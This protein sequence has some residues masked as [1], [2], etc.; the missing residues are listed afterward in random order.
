MPGARGNGREPLF[1]REGVLDE[2]DQLLDR[3]REGTGHLL[4]LEGASGSGKTHVIRAVVDRAAGRDV[5]VLFGRALPEELPVPFSLVRDLVGSMRDAGGG[6]QSSDAVEM[7]PPFLP[8]VGGHLAGPTTASRDDVRP[9]SA[10]DD[11]DRI[12]APLGRSS[13][14]GLEAGR[15]GLLGKVAEYFRSLTADRPIL[16]AVDDL[17]FADTS[18]L[19]F[20][21]RFARELPTLRAVVVATVDTEHPGSGAADTAVAALRRA[22]NFRSLDVRPL[23]MPEATEFVRWVLG[24]REPDRRDVLRWHAQTEGNPLF[25][26][27]LVRA[28][29]G[30]GPA[31]AARSSPGSSATEILVARARGL[32]EPD[33]RVLTYAAVLGK[34]FAFPDLAAVVGLPEDRV[35]E[36]LDRLVQNGLVR[37]KGNEVYEF[38]TEAV[39]ARLYSDLTETRRRIL[40]R[41]AGEALEARGGP[42]ASELARQFYLGRD[43]AR[44][45]RYCVAAADV[46]L[47]SYAFETAAAHLARA[48]E[49][50][51]R[52]PDRDRRVE[53][54]LLT[55]LGRVHNEMGHREPSEEAFAE[56]IRLARTDPALALELGRG[57]LGLADARA[58]W[59]EYATAEELATEASNLLATAGTDRDRMATHRVLSLVHWRQG[60]LA[61]AEENARA[62]LEIAEREGTPLELGHALVDLAIVMSPRGP[63]R[64]HPALELLSRAAELFARSDDYSARARAL[65]DRAVL[66]HEAARTDEALRDIAL[67]I[68]AAER[69]RS[70][71]WI[72]YCHLNLAQWQAARGHPELARPALARAV[73]VLA[74]SGD[75]LGEQQAE[76]ARGMIAHADHQFD[77]AEASYQ[78]ALRQSHAM[79]LGSDALESLVRLAQL[80]H[81]R[82]DDDEARARVAEVRQNPY[83]DHRRDLAA[84]VAELEQAL[85]V[86]SSPP[87]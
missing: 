56:A 33:R 11:L 22:P 13:V 57:L 25:L 34:E 35:T 69:S 48:L 16:I 66:E 20:L 68:D 77:R 67:A 73:Q 78:E 29:I 58:G 31:L 84:M 12:L 65:M 75:R 5:R 4:F 18:S 55:D 30:E 60:D 49:A 87:R 85:A 1:G 14:E 86:G 43:D 37:E 50:E 3:A 51:R 26:E 83:L 42:R 39:R 6:P 24:G 64:L 2:I 19:E 23:S 74:A 62:A 28:A 46:A 52:L 40:H 53:L 71:A 61:T 41:R 9:T 82:G 27:Q 59:G 81:D 8:L 10:Q 44:A 72:G 17:S 38:V 32:D 21:Q 15:E 80:S 45:V 70:P 79:H 36:S 63:T 54:R 47:R 76:L 7:L